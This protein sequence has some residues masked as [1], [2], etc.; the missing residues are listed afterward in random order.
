[1]V[2]NHIERQILATTVRIELHTWATFGGH[3]KP[4]ITTSHAT[5]LDGRYLITHNHFKYALTEQ[6]VENGEK[7]GYT[8]ISIRTTQGELLLD[9]AP[10]ASFR[11]VHSDPETLVLAFV[12]EDGN[13]LFDITGLPSAPLNNWSSVGWQSGVELAQ[14]DWNGETAHVDWVL[15]ENVSLTGEV[16]Q[17]QVDNYAMIGSSGGGV[18]WNGV[19]VGNN[20]ARNYEKDPKTGEIVRRYSIIALNS[21]AVRDLEE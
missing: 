9:N 3:S 11:V 2:C 1:M 20:W 8:G 7:K 13:G 19:H 5:I 10:L 4:I 21:A 6:V 15:I 18:F 12:D 17:I 16:P 14:I